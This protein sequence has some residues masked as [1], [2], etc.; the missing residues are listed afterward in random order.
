[1]ATFALQ[2]DVHVCG[3]SRGSVKGIVYWLQKRCMDCVL[4]VHECFEI[5]SV[6]GVMAQLFSSDCTGRKSLLKCTMS[7]Y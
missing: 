2:E 7:C 1:M 3:I 5:L 6:W 4:Y